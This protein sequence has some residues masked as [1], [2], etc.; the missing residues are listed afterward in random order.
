MMRKFQQLATNGTILLAVC[1]AGCGS[2][3]KEEILA[4]NAPVVE[5][6]QPVQN[7]VVPKEEYRI[8]K[9]EKSWESL[10]NDVKVLAGVTVTLEIDKEHGDE[11]LKEIALQIMGKDAKYTPKTQI[12][13]EKDKEVFARLEY[14]REN[15]TSFVHEVRNK[16]IAA[17]QKRQEEQRQRDE[18]ARLVAEQRRQEEQKRLQ[19]E[20]R[21]RDTALDLNEELRKNRYNPADAESVNAFVSYR[22]HGEGTYSNV[23]ERNLERINE[24]GPAFDEI[25][26][27]RDYDYSVGRIRD[28]SFEMSIDTDMEHPKIDKVSFPVQGVRSDGKNL[29]WMHSIR[30]S[31][32]GSTNNIR[33]LIN[34]K[35]KYH[36]RVYLTNMRRG[37]DRPYADI[38]EIVIVKTSEE[39]LAKMVAERVAGEREREAKI[40]AKRDAVR[41]DWRTQI[42]L[43]N[44][45]Q[46][47]NLRQQERARERDFWLYGR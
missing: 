16:R 20:Q 24:Y 19:E 36:A 43:I 22:R 15:L 23:P 29:V 30:F 13:F 45:W 9:N 35:D 37:V 34:N 40:E 33:E 8:L 2:E 27:F 26:F 38:Q 5:I 3:Q 4:Q 10:L 1:F 6:V 46:E 7:V 31:V 25:V 17:E 32:N 42:N 47:Y 41:D 12:V 18:Q 21:F 28:S 39:Q 44:E 11:K 14:E